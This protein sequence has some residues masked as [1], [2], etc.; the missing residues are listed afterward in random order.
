MQTKFADF[1]EAEYL[2]RS[3]SMKSRGRSK[4]KLDYAEG[5]VS[6]RVPAEKTKNNIKTP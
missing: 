4:R 1:A 6:G 5:C 2:R 3:Q